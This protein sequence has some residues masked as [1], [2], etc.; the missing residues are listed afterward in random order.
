MLNS[1]SEAEMLRKKEKEYL[2]ILDG[3]TEGS[4]IV[5]FQSGITEFSDQWLKRIGEENISEKDVNF[6]TESLLHPE[7]WGRVIKERRFIYKNK[8]P[9]YKIEY[10]LK[11]VDGG[12]IWVLDQGKNNI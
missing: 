11:T 5:D 7:D 4:W 3:S 9:K 10:R 1:T 12:Y 8:L 6:Y 2:E